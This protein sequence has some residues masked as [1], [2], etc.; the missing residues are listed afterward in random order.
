V[1]ESPTRSGRITWLIRASRTSSRDFPVD[2]VGFC[3]HEAAPL[4]KAQEYVKKIRKD[5][6]SGVMPSQRLVIRRK[7]IEA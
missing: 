2:R 3:R 7:S 6:V 4:F 1:G 5:V